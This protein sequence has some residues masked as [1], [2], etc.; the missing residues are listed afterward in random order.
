MV[1]AVEVGEVA[2][3]SGQVVLARH[4]MWRQAKAGLITP[5]TRSVVLVGEVMEEPGQDLAKIVLTDLV[6]G[7]TQFFGVEV[8]PFILEKGANYIQ[9]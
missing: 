3:T 2:Y 7:L 9:W 6:A 1:L 8:L 4:L 5:T